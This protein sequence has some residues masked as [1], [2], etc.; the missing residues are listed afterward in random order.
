MRKILY[1][2]LLA[3]FAFASILTSCEQKEDYVAT[4]DIIPYPQELNLR[5]GEHFV[6]NNSTSIVYPQNNETLKQTALFLSEYLQTATGLKLNVTSEAKADNAIILNTGYEHQNKE[7]YTLTVDVNSINISGASENGVFYGIQTLRKTIGGTKQ[8]NTI[9][10]PQVEIHDYPRFAYRGMMLDVSRHFYPIEFL[11]KFVDILALH[12][13]NNFH[14]HLSDDQGWRVEIKKYP[15]LTT[16]GSKREKTL[17]GKTQEYDNTPHGGFYTQEELKD[18]VS[19]AQDRFINIVPEIDLPGHT[20]SV[21]AAYPDLGCTGGPYKVSPEWGVFD[22]VLCIGND[23]VYE[24]LEGIFTEL[25]EIFPSE[26]IHIG[27]DEAPRHRWRECTKCQARI[28]AEGLKTDAKYKAED[29][30]QAYFMTRMNDIVKKIGRKAIGWDEILHGEVPADITVASWHG[31]TGGIEGAK[32][33]HE[34]IMVPNSH[35]Y[36]DFYQTRNIENVPLAIGGFTPLERVYEL[37]PIPAELTKEQQGLI[38]GLQA[39]LWSE[40]ILSPEQAEYMVL[41]RIA[42]LAEVQ[43]TMPEKKNYNSFL[44]RTFHLTTIYND[45]KYNYAKHMFDINGEMDIAYDKQSLKVTLSTFGDAPIYYTLDGTK[46]TKD[47]QLY[48]DP[49]EIKES[50]KLNAVA[51]RPIGESLLYSQD[52]QFNKATLRPVKVLAEMDAY[53][54][55]IEEGMTDGLFGGSGYADGKWKGVLGENVT[56]VVDL[57]AATEISSVTLGTYVSVHDW[58]FGMT[59][60]E[61]LVSDNGTDYKSVSL[62]SYPEATKET[63]AA[64]VDLKAEFSPV[65]TRYVKLQLEKTDMLPSWHAGVGGR[66]YTFIDEVQIK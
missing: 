14:I 63:P 49:I 46:P 47:S 37:E 66:A 60:Y 26:Y 57:K 19:Y 43:W 22:D 42:A 28:K 20:L 23:K 51:I 27:G 18:L 54:D 33:G 2:A 38:K 53:G 7:A 9:K 55:K 59:K 13:I 21:L 17:I 64:R 58:I 12:N 11:K 40:Y 24:V 61:V 8:A 32:R 5:E 30:L 4:Y 10:L 56:I 16:I 29:R 44:T 41:P 34:V 48:T 45:L 52:F 31:L 6:L 50:Q 35:C 62:E 36:F 3:L 1:S 15:E 25:A 65:T 39:N